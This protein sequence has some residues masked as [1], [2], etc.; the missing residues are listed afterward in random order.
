MILEA[1]MLNVKEEMTDEFEKAFEKA[2]HIISSREGYIS[3][4]L[5][6]SIETPNSYL[7][8]VRWQNLEDHTIGFRQSEEYKE[9]KSLLHHFY[10]PF[11]R[12]EHYQPLN[13]YTKE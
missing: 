2:S 7:L 9:W 1:A 6:K 4:E 5:N 3:H 11:P 12:V 10:E 13:S 8:L